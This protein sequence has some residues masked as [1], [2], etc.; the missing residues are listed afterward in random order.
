MIRPYTSAYQ[1][2]DQKNGTTTSAIA[3]LQSVLDQQSDCLLARDWDGLHETY[4]LPYKRVFSNSETVIE[5]RTD[6]QI[7]H[8]SFLGSLES[9]GVNQFIRLATDAEFLGKDYV[10]G[11]YISH[12]LRGT[13]PMVPSYNNRVVLK[14]QNTSWRVIEMESNVIVPHWP[15]DLSIKPTATI[16]PNI[17][18]KNDVRRSL[19]EPV[20]LYQTF[21]DAHGQSIKDKDFETFCSLCCFPY[22]YHNLSI[23]IVVNGPEDLIDVFKDLCGSYDGRLGDNVV[24]TADRAE[25]LQADLICGY[26]TACVYRDGKQSGQPLQSRMLL[27]RH[28]IEW[29]LESVTN[30]LENNSFSLEI[31]RPNSQLPTLR[32]IQERTKS[33][34]TSL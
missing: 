19:A 33:W 34:P 23:D 5:T 7:G 26:H 2:I 24:R 17:G 14:R 13:V 9:L 4:S 20:S 1:D 25:F 30:A 16:T 28:N 15:P 21:L 3:I 29:R 12:A 10:E 27:K 31:A 22:T 11:F 32:E 18:S 6:M 8:E